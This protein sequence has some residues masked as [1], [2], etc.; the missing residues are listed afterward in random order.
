MRL[1][2]ADLGHLR[3]PAVLHWNFQHFVVLKH[4]TSGGAVIHDPAMGVRRVRTADLSQNFPGVAVELWPTDQFQPR[5]ERQTHSWRD[6]I[7][8][9]RGFAGFVGNL[10]VVGFCLSC[11]AS[12]PLCSRNG[13]STTSRRPRTLTC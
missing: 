2:L 11:S 1:D 5:D 7:G 6:L 8:K 13:R 4:V 12:S 9:P 10:L 3:T